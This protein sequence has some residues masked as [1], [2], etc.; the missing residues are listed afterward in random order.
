M[1]MKKESIKRL[2]YFAKRYK[3]YLFHKKHKWLRF[4]PFYGLQ[5]RWIMTLWK[6][7]DVDIKH[8]LFLLSHIQ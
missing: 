6:N 5:Y 3:S 1:D 4:M 8:E 2:I 7:C